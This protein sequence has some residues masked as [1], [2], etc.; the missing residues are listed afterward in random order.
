MESLALVILVAW[1]IYIGGY[2][3]IKDGRFKTGFRDNK[4]GGSAWTKFKVSVVMLTTAALLYAFADKKETKS[5][6][7]SEINIETVDVA[8]V[9]TKPD[10]R[11]EVVGEIDKNIKLIG[12]KKTKYFIKIE[13]KN[14]NSKII[15]GYVLLDKIKFN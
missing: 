2:G 3:L 8:K 13:Y 14:G 12:T 10:E 15:K 4:T 7:K 6:N 9:F 5:S 11:A 1:F